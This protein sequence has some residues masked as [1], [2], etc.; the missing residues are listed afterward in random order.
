MLIHHGTANPVEKMEN[1]QL[2]RRVLCPE[3]FDL[4]LGE[5]IV[6]NID[7]ELPAHL[8]PL[9]NY[10]PNNKVPKRDI[11][12]LLQSAGVCRYSL[13][14]NGHP[15]AIGE[16][17]IYLDDDATNTWQFE[18]RLQEL[19]KLKSLYG[20][21]GSES[22]SNYRLKGQFK[23]IIRRTNIGSWKEESND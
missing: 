22:M 9:I 7:D 10:W 1:A 6:T 2:S 12:L 23:W 21:P 4:E 14:S 3:G 11:N 17:F 15:V 18:K 16:L 8:G 5:F 20:V 13:S 19:I